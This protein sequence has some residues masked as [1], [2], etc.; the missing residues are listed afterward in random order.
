MIA[1]SNSFDGFL[2]IA[3][4]AAISTPLVVG[5]GVRSAMASGLRLWPAILTTT[6]AH[7]LSAAIALVPTW[8]ADYGL[9]R[10]VIARGVY[11]TESVNSEYGLALGLAI[12]FYFSYTLALRSFA[13]RFL[14]ALQ[15]SGQKAWATGMSLSM[16]GSMILLLLFFFG[17]ATGLGHD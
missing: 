12:V 16:L 15:P 7:V 13:P 5:V 4:L 2:G 3:F 8:L 17:V 6:G 11:S 9:N 14:D 10:G 1:V